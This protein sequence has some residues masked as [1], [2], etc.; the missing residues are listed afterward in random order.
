MLSRPK[1]TAFATHGMS[2]IISAITHAFTLSSRT[3]APFPFLGNQTNI[4]QLAMQATIGFKCP[5]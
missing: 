4:K 5:A 1:P 3:A 2:A